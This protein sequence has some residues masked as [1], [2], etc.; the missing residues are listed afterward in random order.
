MGAN[1]MT[2]AHGVVDAF[3]GG[4]Q[5]AGITSAQT[6]EA[7]NCDHVDRPEQYGQ[8][9]LSPEPDCESLRFLVQYGVAS[10]QTMAAPTLDIRLWIAGSTRPL[11]SRPHWLPGQ[12]SAHSFGNAKIGNLRGPNLVDFDLVLQKNFKIGERS[13]SNSAR[14]SSISSI[15][16]ISVCREGAPW[17][18][19]MCRE[20]PRS[21]TRRRTTAR[22]SSR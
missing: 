18:R 2:D 13:R 1:F 15:I 20:A 9:Q 8:L 12:Q 22:S 21:R 10:P 11:S 5:V 6:G 7:V 3:L 17:L 19:S 16:R 14:S 4:W